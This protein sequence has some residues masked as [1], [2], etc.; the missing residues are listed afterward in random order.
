M[1]DTNIIKALTAL[2]KPVCGAVF[3]GRSAV[4]FPKID[5]DLRQLSQDGCLHG[6]RLVLDIY[7]N[8]GDYPAALDMADRVRAALSLQKGDIGGGFLSVYHGGSRYSVPEKDNE[9][10]IHITDS[11]EV[12]FYD[13]EE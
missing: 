3:F 11:Y 6:F 8:A 10:I 4:K 2:I 13:R 12:Y 5:C 1:N 9:K 7:T